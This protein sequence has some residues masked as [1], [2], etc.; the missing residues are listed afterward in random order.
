MEPVKPVDDGADFDAAFAEAVT[1]V[2]AE[3]AA[4]S[5]PA[6]ALAAEAPAA[7]A[8]EAAKPEAEVAAPEA[9]KP[10]A[11]LA[12]VEPDVTKV[13][14]DGFAKLTEN[15]TRVEPA[16]AEPAKP[17][18]KP[19][20]KPFELSEEQ[21]KQLE[22]FE[23]EW[24]DVAPVVALRQQQAI[25]DV[26]LKFS[27]ALEAVLQ[28]VQQ[29]LSPV[30]HS[31]TTTDAKSH[32][33]AIHEAHKDFD[34]IVDLVPEWIAKQPEYLKKAYASV[35]ESGT[36]QEVIDLATRFKEATGR[37]TPKEQNSPPANPKTVVDPA[38]VAALA[39]VGAQR[40]TVAGSG[41]D[42]MDYDA[43]F[44]EAVAGKR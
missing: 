41:K 4:E 13:I 15:L 33:S 17:E 6:E 23:K 36:A 12:K 2:K 27:K 31:Q 37:V 20:Q 10:E 32:F 18:P 21:K 44:A 19:E 16:K 11:A 35:Y 8:P 30:I 25:H 39:P 29:Q 38:T 40:T 24:P 9:T 7:A 43:A 22:S 1:G 34:A 5:K 14:S 42:P 28:S 3:P 26:E